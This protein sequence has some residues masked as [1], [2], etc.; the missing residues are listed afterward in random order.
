M[1][2]KKFKEK[3][4]VFISLP[5]GAEKLVK[6]EFKMIDIYTCRYVIANKF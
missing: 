3:V 1:N 2:E 6:E 4:E 5:S